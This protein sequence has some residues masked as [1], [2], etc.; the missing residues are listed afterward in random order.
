M[1]DVVERLC[2]RSLLVFHTSNPIRKA[3]VL[4]VHWRLFDW[5]TL[6]MILGN[7]VVLAMDSNAPGFPQ[8]QEVHAL[9]SMHTCRYEH[10]T[11]MSFAVAGQDAE[12]SGAR[13]QSITAQQKK[14]HGSSS[15]KSCIII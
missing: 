10:V 9:N 11:C 5:L 7:C 1:Q 13:T 12:S 8:S 2:T 4:L 6:L 14:Q 3:A 15:I